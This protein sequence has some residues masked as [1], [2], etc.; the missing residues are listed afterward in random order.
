MCNVLSE[1]FSS[2]QLYIE[3]KSA[4]ND[5]HSTGESA[6]KVVPTANVLTNNPKKLQSRLNCIKKD[7]QYQTFL[8]SCTDVHDRTRLL[9]CGGPNDESWLDAI[10][11]SQHFTLGNAQFRIVCLLQLRVAIPTLSN[12]GSCVSSCA[13]SIDHKGY[14]ACARIL[15]Y[16]CTCIIIQTTGSSYE[17]A[18][19]KYTANK[20]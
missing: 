15:I 14:H 10:P 6:Q 8:E 17:F 13:K 19:I 7:K 1:K 12:F 20:I 9:S 4:L 16:T 2:R 11:S 3:L 18:I 5:L